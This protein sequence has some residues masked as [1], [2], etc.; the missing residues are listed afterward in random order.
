[1]DKTTNYYEIHVS[2]DDRAIEI[3]FY[4]DWP[5]DVCKWTY[6]G[7]IERLVS[8]YARRFVPWENI[9]TLEE[10]SHYVFAWPQHEANIKADM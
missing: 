6:L 4:G 5:H 10:G 7:F 8:A 1:M 9:V 3:M 2:R